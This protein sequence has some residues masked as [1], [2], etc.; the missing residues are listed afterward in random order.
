MTK[1]KAERA[2]PG[3]S[4]FFFVVL[5]GPVCLFFLLLNPTKRSRSGI[6]QLQRRIT[7]A[8]TFDSSQAEFVNLSINE[9]KLNTWQ[10]TDWFQLSQGQEY[11][12]SRNIIA[13][14]LC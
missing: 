11:F 12:I 8:V 7:E 1:K 10:C 5:F 9:N 6:L 13:F 2:S 14:I 4:F 3:A